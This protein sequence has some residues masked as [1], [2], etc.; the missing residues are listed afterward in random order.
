MGYTNNFSNWKLVDG[1]LIQ[2]YIIWF[3]NLFESRKDFIREWTAFKEVFTFQFLNGEIYSYTKKKPFGTWQFGN[4]VVLVNFIT[5]KLK[6][7]LDCL[8]FLWVF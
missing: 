1:V 6:K 8:S 4:I 7:H 5:Q 3:Y 2:V